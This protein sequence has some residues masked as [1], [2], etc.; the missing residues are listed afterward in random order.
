MLQYTQLAFL[1]L[2][3][4]AEIE[5]LAVQAIKLQTIYL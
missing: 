1:Q 3:M 2:H 5:L 4:Y